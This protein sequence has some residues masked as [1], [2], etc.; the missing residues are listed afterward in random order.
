MARATPKN[1][2]PIQALVKRPSIH[3]SV[4]LN[5]ISLPKRIFHTSSLPGTIILHLD[6]CIWDVPSSETSLILA[7]KCG[8][9]AALSFYYI[10]F[11]VPGWSQ[12]KPVEPPYNRTY[13][14]WK[15]TTRLLHPPPVLHPF[16]EK[17]VWDDIYLVEGHD[18]GQPEV[19]VMWAILKALCQSCCTA[20]FI[21]S[22]HGPSW[23][24]R[25][26]LIKRGLHRHLYKTR[27]MTTL[28]PMFFLAFG[29]SYKK[30][31]RQRSRI[32]PRGQFL[33]RS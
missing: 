30:A 9:Q 33:C 12:S 22:L 23:S 28:H 17:I 18:E 26:I 14:S 1:E 6:P 10:Q 21:C 2:V 20:W 7:L 19:V 5:P 27:V 24:I 8:D 11:V 13:L 4:K 31:M 25:I 15:I 16:F 3:A 29:K 32:P